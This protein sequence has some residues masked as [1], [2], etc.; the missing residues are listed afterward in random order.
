MIKGLLTVYER[1]NKEKRNTSAIFAIVSA[2]GPESVAIVSGE[3]FDFS[4]EEKLKSARERIK[5]DQVSAYFSSLQKEAADPTIV[6]EVDD[7][8]K[9]SLST[10][11]RLGKIIKG[12]MS[13]DK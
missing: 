6:K 4:N 7:D 10:L 8:K 12:F 13:L 11:E 5:W 2:M 9:L 1:I 3:G